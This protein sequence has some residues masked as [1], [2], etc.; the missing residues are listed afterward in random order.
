MRIVYKNSPYFIPEL[1]D[2]IIRVISEIE[3]QLCL[4][5]VEY[6]N[7]DVYRAARDGYLADNSLHT[8][9]S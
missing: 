7:K 1:K 6:F 8:K 5:V 2:E 3:S 9:M 4:H